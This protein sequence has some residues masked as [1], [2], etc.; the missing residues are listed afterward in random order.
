MGGTQTAERIK[1]CAESEEAKD[2]VEEDERGEDN[3]MFDL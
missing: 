3:S 2:E 1:E